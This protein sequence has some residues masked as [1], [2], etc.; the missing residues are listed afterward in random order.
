MSDDFKD[1][2]DAAPNPMVP[3]GRWAQRVEPQGIVMKSML[4]ENSAIQLS[5]ADCMG[6]CG[7]IV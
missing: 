5:L 2:D 1:R 4:D 6:K 7:R 3:R